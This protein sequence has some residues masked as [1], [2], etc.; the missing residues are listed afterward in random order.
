MSACQLLSPDGVKKWSV[1]L[2]TR[3]HALDFTDYS[4]GIDGG[5]VRE[6]DL[7]LNWYLNAGSRI[8]LNWMRPSLAGNGTANIVQMRFQV[9]F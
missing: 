9:N 4:A 8:M 6:F 1:Q 7:G 3:Y 5:K 2:V